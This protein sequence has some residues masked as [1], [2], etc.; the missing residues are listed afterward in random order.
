MIDRDWVIGKPL[1]FGRISGFS[2]HQPSKFNPLLVLLENTLVKELFLLDGQNWNVDLVR[3]LFWDDEACL[4]LAT[5][6]SR[7]NINDKYI[8]ALIEDGIF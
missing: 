3:S 2:C 4:I 8:W 1:E 6:I 5:P 7:C